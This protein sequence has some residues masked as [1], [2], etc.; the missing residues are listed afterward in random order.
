MGFGSVKGVQA[1]T[2]LVLDDSQDSNETSDDSEDNGS[3]SHVF[4][5]FEFPNLRFFHEIVSIIFYLKLK[6]IYSY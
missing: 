3:S 2:E 5:N 1:R 4:T 6:L